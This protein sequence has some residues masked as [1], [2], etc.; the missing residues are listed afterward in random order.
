MDE[1]AGEVCPEGGKKVRDREYFR[2]RRAIRH[3]ITREHGLPAHIPHGWGAY[4]NWGCR[5]EVCTREVREYSRP[6]KLAWQ[7]KKRAE[8][9]AEKDKERG[10]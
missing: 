7:K 2:T 3:Q 4:N 9:V 1:K 8:K 10:S 5:C 6:Y